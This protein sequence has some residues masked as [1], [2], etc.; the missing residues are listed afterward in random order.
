MVGREVSAHHNLCGGDPPGS[1]GREE[2]HPPS[3]KNTPPALCRFGIL[4]QSLA[5]RKTMQTLP[6]TCRADDIG[7]TEPKRG[8]R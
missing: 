7:H 3:H 1:G 4:T 8:D 6:T 2:P 5:I